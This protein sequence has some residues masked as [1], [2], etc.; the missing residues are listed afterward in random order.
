[1]KGSHDEHQLSYVFLHCWLCT[2]VQENIGQL[3]FVV[4]TFQ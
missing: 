4:G 1:L 3:M 2:T